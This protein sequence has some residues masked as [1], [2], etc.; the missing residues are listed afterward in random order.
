ME[1]IIT[2]TPTFDDALNA[3]ILI[4]KIIKI[5]DEQITKNWRCTLVKGT[6][7]TNMVFDTSFGPVTLDDFPA[8]KAYILA[9]WAEE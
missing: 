7:L 9:K 1:T 6:D 2:M 3:N 8:E 5:D 4:K